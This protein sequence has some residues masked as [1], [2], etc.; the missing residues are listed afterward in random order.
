MSRRRLREGEEGAMG[1]GRRRSVR[2]GEKDWAEIVRRFEGG[3]LSSAAFCRRE[4]VALSSL[5][6]WRHRI[7]RHGS[8]RFVELVPTT[9]AA[10][11]PSAAGWFLELTLPNGASI[12]LQG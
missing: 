4:G 10:S 7:A 2:R 1:R 11:S 3:G 5:Q 8:G 6:R 12:R 9:G